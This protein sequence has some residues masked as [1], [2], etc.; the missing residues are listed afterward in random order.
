MQVSTVLNEDFADATKFA[1]TH[2]VDTANRKTAWEFLEYLL[3]AVPYQIYT[4]LPD[5]GIQLAE[6]P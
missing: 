4:I 6:Q 5:N 1:V 2:L 3:E